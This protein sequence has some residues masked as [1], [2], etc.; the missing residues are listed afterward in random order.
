MAALAATLKAGKAARRRSAAPNA[1]AVLKSASATPKGYRDSGVRRSRAHTGEAPQ[2]RGEGLVPGGP[3]PMVKVQRM[4]W[5]GDADAA[6]A[7]PD[8]NAGPAGDASDAVVDKH[9]YTGEHEVTARSG[10]APAQTPH[11]LV[12][13]G[14]ND[15]A[16]TLTPES[17]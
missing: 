13:Q 2:S 10:S 6:S 9:F 5:P 1:A 11:G 7:L 16:V 4:S 14:A 15:Y 8:R 3:L 12:C 17:N